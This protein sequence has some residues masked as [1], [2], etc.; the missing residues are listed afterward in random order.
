MHSI[1][2]LQVSNLYAVTSYLPVTE[3]LFA[4]EYSL[5]KKICI[6]TYSKTDFSSVQGNRRD[7]RRIIRSA[8]D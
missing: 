5:D 1:S 6:F 3:R 2:F 4:C 7:K 8:H